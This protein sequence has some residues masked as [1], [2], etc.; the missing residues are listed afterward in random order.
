MQNWINILTNLP[1]SDYT[2]LLAFIAAGGGVSVAL[3]VI[4]HFKG[5]NSQ[6]ISRTL[7]TIFSYVVAAANYILSTPSRSL[8]VLFA[9]TA[10][11]MSAAH[12]VYWISVSPG[13][14]WLI[15]LLTDAGS[16]RAISAPQK[17]S[18]AE[19]PPE[20]FAE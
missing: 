9:H 15:T 14:K 3:Q 1:H 7:L 6:A 16:Y 18:V 4:K 20:Q 19:A 5:I 11:I 8:S 17:A 12:V 13:Y 2:A 10:I